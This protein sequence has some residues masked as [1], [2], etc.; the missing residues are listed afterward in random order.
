MLK[1]IIKNKRKEVE[2]SKKQMPLDS[3]KSKIIKSTRSFKDALSKNKINLIAEIKR[4]SPSQNRINS[5][6]DLKDIVS[7]Y[8]KYA[9][10]ISVLTDKK[11]FDGSLEDLK[12]V[13]SLTSLPILRK[14]FIIDEYQIYEAR[15]FGADAILLIASVLSLDEINNFMD[16]AKS[17]GIDCLVEVHNTSELNK[18]LKSKA[19]IIGIN[20]RNLDTLEIDLNTTLELMNQIPDDKIIVSE[21]GITSNNYLEKIKQKVNAVLVGTYFMRSSNPENDI[22]NFLVSKTKNFF[23]KVKICGI[24]NY[25]DAKNAADL[26]ADFLGFN[27]Y[28]RSPRCVDLR[29]AKNIIGKLNA[30]ILKVGV[31]VNEKIDNVIEIAD[32]C[33]LDLIQ[34]SGD[35]KPHYVDE[36]KNSINKKIIKTFRVKNKI[37]AE[38]INSFNSEYIMIDSFNDGIYG[39]TGQSFDLNLADGFDNTKLFLAGGLNEKNVTAAIKKI[40][41]FAVDVCSSIEKSSGKKDYEK[42][43]RFIEAAK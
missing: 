36:I 20:N 27:F 22:K 9:D 5:K 4:S 19:K 21:S 2:L 31:F 7:I 32:Y 14:D 38:L 10:A 35:E 28:S 40:N 37:N 6:P 18:V 29:T 43:K 16:I 23:V 13:S 39:G 41:P 33:N 15:F 42:M 17:L 8:S 34:L 24:T 1:Q 3:F 30:N 12:N 11:F 25:E 26:G